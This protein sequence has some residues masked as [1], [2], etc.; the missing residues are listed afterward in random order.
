MADALQNCRQNCRNCKCDDLHFRL[1]TSREYHRSF[2]RRCSVSV[3]IL[4]EREVHRHKELLDATP[5]ARRV[6]QPKRNV[7]DGV[8]AAC[9]RRHREAR[10]APRELDPTRLSGLVVAFFGFPTTSTHEPSLASRASR[11]LGVSGEGTHR[12]LL[13]RRNGVRRRARGRCDRRDRFRVG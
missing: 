4:S 11:A 7:G 12:P 2:F 3:F 13:S 10:A 1:Q 9:A 8:L 5:T 6:S